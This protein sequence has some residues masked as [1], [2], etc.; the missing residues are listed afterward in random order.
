MDNYGIGGTGG[1]AGHGCL[2]TYCSTRG[3]GLRVAEV[4]GAGAGSRKT[5]LTRLLANVCLERTAVVV[6]LLECLV[7]QRWLLYYCEVG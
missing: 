7:S 1:G 5:Q 3:G 6:P 4:F 2:G